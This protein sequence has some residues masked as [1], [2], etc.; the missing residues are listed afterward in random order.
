PD[1]GVRNTDAHR[2]ELVEKGDR[3]DD[4]GV[5]TCPLQ[6]GRQILQP[7]PDEIGIQFPAGV[8]HHIEAMASR[9]STPESGQRACGKLL[10]A[11]RYQPEARGPNE[12][13]AI[14]DA[15]K[16]RFMSARLQPACECSHR[17]HVPRE[18]HAHEAKLHTFS[19]QTRRRSW[20]RPRWPPLFPASPMDTSLAP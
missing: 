1:V 15:E 18:G 16:H 3:V 9:D 13:F 12:G 14:R 20:W 6:R 7:H 4:D 2:R 11:D 19:P 5:D 8:T 17:V 10:F